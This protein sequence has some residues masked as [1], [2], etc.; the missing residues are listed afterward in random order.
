VDDLRAE[1]DDLEGAG[2]EA[3]LTAVAEDWRAAGLG[4]VDASLAEFAEK[5]TLRPSE[6]NEGDV[7]TL[8]DHGFSDEGVHDVVQVVSYFNYI[9]RVADALHV[10]VEPGMIPYPGDRDPVARP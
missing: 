9:N 6:M 1:V 5:L 3:W 7:R 4:P 2:L 10:D 8:H